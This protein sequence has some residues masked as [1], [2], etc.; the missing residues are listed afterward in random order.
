MLGDAQGLEGRG[1]VVAPFASAHPLN[2]P[3]WTSAYFPRSVNHGALGAGLGVAERVATAMRVVHNRGAAAAFD[4]FAKVA[5]PD[6]VHQHGLARQFSPSVIER[7]H[8][9]GLPTVLTLHDYGMRCPSG[10]LSRPG[11]AVCLNVSCAGHRYDRSVR[12]ACVHGSRI[13]S[14]LAAAELLIARALRRYERSVDQFLVPSEFLA[15]RMIE[16][17][18]PADRLRVVPNAI[19]S[20]TGTSTG[21]GD[22]ILAYGRLAPTKGFRLVIEVARRMPATRFVIAGDGPDR[23]ELV[24]RASGL[25]N[26][27]FEGHVGEERV[28]GV[29]AGSSCGV[30]TFRRP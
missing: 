27:V 5:R 14:A 24:H 29:V 4:R 16:A 26:V 8:A 19:V 10:N 22:Y 30:G 25:P 28:P 11:E 15:A 7:A 21:D 13:A 12:F 23:G 20:T 6:V 9:R 18:L 1:H 2:Q 17:G 3:T